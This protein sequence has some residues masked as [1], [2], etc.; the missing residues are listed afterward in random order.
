MNNLR[1]IFKINEIF[2]RT[3]F[4][5]NNCPSNLDE[6]PENNDIELFSRHE[7]SSNTWKRELLGL[8]SKNTANSSCELFTSWKIGELLISVFISLKAFLIIRSLIEKPVD[9]V[10]DSEQVVSSVET[11]KLKIQCST[12][13][14][15]CIES[16]IDIK[17]N[18]SVSVLSDCDS[19]WT[20]NERDLNTLLNI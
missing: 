7:Y 19:W 17:L 4:W 11:W 16:A 5:T 9:M 3:R 20:H 15:I 1:F 14:K 8:L 18:H 2:S 13:S 6:L 10:S 12:I